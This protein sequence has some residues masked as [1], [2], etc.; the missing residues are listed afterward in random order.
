MLFDT[1]LQTTLIY[2]RNTLNPITTLNPK[3]KITQVLDPASDSIR[4]VAGSGAA[5]M[6]DGA[7]G[8]ARLSEPA[9][10]CAGPNGT[11]LVA[12]TN[13]SAIRCAAIPLLPTLSRWNNSSMHDEDMH[14]IHISA[15]QG[16]CDA[17]RCILASQSMAS[18]F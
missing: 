4:S 15:V 1:T 14:A 18:L 11:V 10:L 6:A 12:D 5:G 16:H 3:G 8:N 7:G 9:G 13:N 17:S 2:F